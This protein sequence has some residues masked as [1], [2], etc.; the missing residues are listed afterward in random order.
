MEPEPNKLG[1]NWI[2]TVILVQVKKVIL[3]TTKIMTSPTTTTIT[4]IKTTTMIITTTITMIIIT[5]NTAKM[6]TVIIKNFKGKMVLGL[7]GQI[8][9]TGKK[10]EVEQNTL[11]TTKRLLIS[12]TILQ[13][14]TSDHHIR[15]SI[16]KQ[17]KRIKQIL[18][19][20]RIKG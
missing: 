11:Q 7:R 14:G 5:I 10:Q 17:I 12:L 16:I 19:F 13:L 2:L 1:N 18:T 15:S 9:S 6:T 20:L 3:M 4:I 8:S